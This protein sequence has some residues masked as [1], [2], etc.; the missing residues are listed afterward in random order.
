MTFPLLF[1]W[2]INDNCVLYYTKSIYRRTRW[3]FAQCLQIIGSVDLFRLLPIVFHSVHLHWYG[4]L[5]FFRLEFHSRGLSPRIDRVRL[6]L[7]RET[8]F[9]RTWLKIWKDE[10][11]L[12]PVAHEARLV[13][14]SCTCADYKCTNKLIF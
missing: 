10:N 2:M 3:Q 8:D 14:L 5:L 7:Q 1:R 12:L 11:A 13:H 9:F 6:F 4:M